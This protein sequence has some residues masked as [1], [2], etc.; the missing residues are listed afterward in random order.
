MKEIS[1][2]KIVLVVTH[3]EE[4]AN[5]YSDRIIKM[6]DGKIVENTYMISVRS[7]KD[8]EQ[9]KGQSSEK[10]NGKIE[11]PLSKVHM[12]LGMSLLMILLDV[13]SG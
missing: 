1:K 7:N 4:L 3:N 10:S 8:N 9:S 5:E 13:V 2:T 12:T 6:K 11:K